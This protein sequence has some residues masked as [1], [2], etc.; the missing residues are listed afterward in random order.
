M[1][2]GNHAPDTGLQITKYTFHFDPNLHPTT[3]ILTKG[4]CS[5]QNIKF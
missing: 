3:N 1:M 5:S 4:K 2:L